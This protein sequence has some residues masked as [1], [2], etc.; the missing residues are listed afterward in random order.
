VILRAYIFLLMTIVSCKSFLLS[1]ANR[2]SVKSISHSHR[3]QHTLLS[4]QRKMGNYMYNILQPYYLYFINGSSRMRLHN[5]PTKAPSKDKDASAETM[6]PYSMSSKPRQ[7]WNLSGLKEETSR[8]YLRAFKKSEK[9]HERLNK[10]TTKSESER[11]EVDRLTIEEVK[12]EIEFIQKRIGD[13]YSLENDLKKVRS[14]SDPVFPDL[15]ERAIVL[16]INDFPPPRVDHQKAKKPKAVPTG[17]RKPYNRYMSADNIL[18]KVGRS[19]ADN[20]DLSLNPEHREGSM[21]WMHVAG[22]PGSHVVIC[23]SDDEFPTTYRQ[24]LIDAALLAAVN[25]KAGQGG[26]VQVTYTRCRNVT[27]P[28]GA[29]AGLVF[30]KGDVAT[31]RVDI[32]AEDTRLERLMAT[33]DKEELYSN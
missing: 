24:T 31:V 26:R 4:R 6:T 18:I 19:A 15:M 16:E 5:H 3:S 32:N 21:W 28:Y 20:D 1:Q 33:K 29:K 2:L 9:L 22:C 23:N 11:S 12:M 30:L 25:S 10:L 13:V 17:P 8:Q 14:V 7:D 27:K